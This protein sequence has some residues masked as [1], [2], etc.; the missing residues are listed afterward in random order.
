[1][2]S[3]IIA[4]QGGF[5]LT[6]DMLDIFV[7]L[8][9]FIT[10]AQ[11]TPGE[12][13]ELRQQLVA[14]FMAAPLQTIVML[15]PLAAVLGWVSSGQQTAKAS[16]LRDRLHAQLYVQYRGSGN[17]C[18]RIIERYVEVVQVDAMAGIALTRGDVDGLMVLAQRWGAARNERVARS[19]AVDQRF[20]HR[21]AVAFTTG[22]LDDKRFLASAEM[23]HEHWNSLTPGTQQQALTTLGR[24]LGEA[25]E[26]VYGD[27][28]EVR[29]PPTEQLIR[30]KRA[31]LDQWDMTAK[32]MDFSSQMNADFLSGFNL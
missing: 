6:S 32:L 31:S 14:Q 22:T 27:R 19:T 8:V 4:Q 18:L 10:R 25:I 2:A 15:M 23:L 9:R 16:E 30:A 28:P 26:Q 21:A 5:A 11:L 3:P 17:A 24:V 1:M 20:A 7:G 29:E 12:V 13:D